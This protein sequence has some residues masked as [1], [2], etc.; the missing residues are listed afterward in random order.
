MIR[1]LFR[2]RVQHETGEDDFAKAVGIDLR[3]T[4]AISDDQSETETEMLYE[5]QFASDEKGNLAKADPWS[6]LHRGV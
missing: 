6:H 1:L 4:Q 2:L 5:I 3:G